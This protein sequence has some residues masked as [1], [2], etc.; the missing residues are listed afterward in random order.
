MKQRWFS[1]DLIVHP[2]R[3]TLHSMVC[4]TARWLNIEICQIPESE[5]KSTQGE[6][7]RGISRH[8]ITIRGRA[9]TQDWA[10]RNR[11]YYIQT[12]AD[13]YSTLVD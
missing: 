2:V 5:Q 3:N 1:D 13:Q 9:W 12:L 7:R 6:G 8:L 10:L 4:V 11:I